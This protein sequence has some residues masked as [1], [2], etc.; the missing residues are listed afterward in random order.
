VAEVEDERR[1]PKPN[2]PQTGGRA[3]R[4]TSRYNPASVARMRCDEDEE[5]LALSIET[6]DMGSAP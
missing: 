3:G 1:A 5:A 4:Y 2:V 6:G